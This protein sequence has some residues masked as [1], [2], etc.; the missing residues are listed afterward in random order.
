MVVELGDGALSAPS[1]VGFLRVEFGLSQRG[2]S[3][4]SHDVMCGHA[5]IGELAPER[6]AQPMWFTIERQPGGGHC[7]PHKAAE[8][9]NH[10]GSAELS[11]DDANMRP[12]RGVQ[13]R[14]PRAFT[15]SNECARPVRQ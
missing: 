1:A 9:I 8:A 12:R 13:C 11:G 4:R 6:L 7:I 14:P 5:G 10:E 3:E 15:R 2:V